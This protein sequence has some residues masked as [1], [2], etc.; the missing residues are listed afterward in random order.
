MEEQAIVFVP[1]SL[2]LGLE[3]KGRFSANLQQLAD[4][5]ISG[6]LASIKLSQFAKLK[7]IPLI[8]QVSFLYLFQV[9]ELLGRAPQKTDNLCRGETPIQIRKKLYI[10]LEKVELVC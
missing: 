8:Y 2:L 10:Y 3:K 1:L 9:D 6:F 4:I 7:F 5:F